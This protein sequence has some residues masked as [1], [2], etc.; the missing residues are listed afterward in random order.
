MSGLK[1]RVDISPNPPETLIKL[2][3]R[4]D[5]LLRVVLVSPPCG[6]VKLTPSSP[7][8]GVVKLT[9]EGSIGLTSLW[10]CETD[11]KLTSLWCCETNTKLT[12]LRCCET[13]TKKNDLHRGC[14]T[15][16]VLEKIVL[17][18]SLIREKNHRMISSFTRNLY[19]DM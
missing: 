5:C 15:Q 14:Q 10:C 4:L 2:R 8:F 3:K 18:F 11:T 12:S 13:N 7:P 19:L 6:V 16:K 1:K 17:L 9:A